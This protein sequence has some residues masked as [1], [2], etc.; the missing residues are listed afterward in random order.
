[1]QIV[2]RDQYRPALGCGRDQREQRMRDAEILGSA[3]GWS[4]ASKQSMDGVRRGSEQ[5]VAIW[6]DVLSEQ[7]TEQLRGDTERQVSLQLSP[8][9]AEH[10]H[11]GGA[12]LIERRLVKPSLAHARVPL[13]QQCGAAATQR[14]GSHAGDRLQRCGSV[15]QPRAPAE[16][17][18]ASVPRLRY[19]HGLKLPQKM[20]RWG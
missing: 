3:S 5:G 16:R 4:F 9:G 1:M 13:E 8:G 6:T 2:H 14:L 17:T 19:R 10:Q 15:Q 12:A 11:A 18:A 7:L 20:V